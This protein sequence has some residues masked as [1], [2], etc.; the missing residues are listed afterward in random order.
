MHLQT[1]AKKHEQIELFW[2]GFGKYQQNELV[3]VVG[4][5]K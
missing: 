5:G 1:K 3:T 2:V 4:D